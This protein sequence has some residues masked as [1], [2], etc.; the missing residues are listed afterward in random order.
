MA[1]VW[2]LPD[3]GELRRIYEDPAYF[4]GAGYYLD[5]LAHEDNHRRLAR[6]L[7][8]RLA[9]F[10]APGG[11]VLDVGAAAGFFLDEA[12]RRG[13]VAT[14]IEPSPAM[15]RHAREALG[16]EVR[17]GSFEPEALGGERF[18]LISFL[19]SL[20][21]FVDPEAQL[22]A[23]HELLEPGGVLALL[24]PNV[25]S[26]LATLLGRRWPHYT[27]PE[28]LWYFSPASL[29]RLLARTG[30][31]VL[32]TSSLGHFW[33]LDELA[34]KLAPRTRHALGALGLER[35]LRRSVYLNV[36]DSFVVGRRGA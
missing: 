28:H 19:D 15:S 33:S 24:T 17:T 1:L 9:P 11:R 4:A 25:Q 16:L 3:A 5:Y 2:P 22:A 20:E 35:L 36:G 6:R 13:F 26:L 27:P 21:H 14:G 23:A 7:L 31:D 12:R 18:A 32:S 29:R 30:F 8:A 10:V 34:T